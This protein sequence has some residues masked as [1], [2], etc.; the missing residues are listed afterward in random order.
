MGILFLA[1]CKLR[2]TNRSLLEG[3]YPG[4]ICVVLEHRDYLQCFVFFLLACFQ[5]TLQREPKGLYLAHIPLTYIRLSLMFTVSEG[6]SLSTEKRN[7]PRV[8]DVQEYEAFC[9]GCCSEQSVVCRRR[10]RI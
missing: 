1:V 9:K 7:E 10:L 8:M 3:A 4:K 6:G 2:P 5:K